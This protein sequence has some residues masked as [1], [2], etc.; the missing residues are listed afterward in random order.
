MTVQNQERTL[1]QLKEFEIFKKTSRRLFAQVPAIMFKPSGHIAQ[2][3]PAAEAALDMKA[4]LLIGKT[5]RQAGCQLLDDTGRRMPRSKQPWFT[6]ISQRSIMS[7][8]VTGM[9]LS[10][11]KIR[12]QQCTSMPLQKGRRKPYACIT[13]FTDITRL[14]ELQTQIVQ[15]QKM[16]AIAALASGLTHDFNNIL[17]SIRSAVQLV[18]VDSALPNPEHELLKDIEN[19][20]LRGAEL[21]KQILL[22]TKPVEQSSGHTYLKHQ[23]HMLRRLIKRT[24]PKNIHVHLDLCEQELRINMNPT[25]F[26]Q[27]L[28]NLIINARDAMRDGGDLNIKLSVV[29]RGSDELPPIP[30][31][32]VRTFAR[33]DVADTGRGIAP[34]NLSRIFEP[35]FTTRKDS[36][37]TGLGLPI[38]HNLVRQSGGQI[39]AE[40]TPG[41][42]SVFSI[43]LPARR[44]KPPEITPPL[45]NA[46]SAPITGYET[47]LVVDDEALITKSTAR[48][49]ERH[50]YHAIPAFEG[51]KALEIFEK[52]K[53]EV[54]LVLLDLEMPELSGRDCLARILAI[55]PGAKVV[56]I[57]GHILK[58]D[59]W[60]PIN[61]G[62]KAF[63]QKPFDSVALLHIVRNLLDA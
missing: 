8:I 7:N 1:R 40:S 13:I 41:K 57:T 42:G 36:G 48:F 62:A 33:V 49:L 51:K 43:L 14:K 18:L 38:V 24:I 39:T 32:R 12:W 31:T 63:V 10:D 52:Q 54:S 26:E 45:W 17:T 2:L 20:T 29:S 30:G 34:E 3:N 6:A 37:G 4:D 50:G 61:A 46:A 47:I 28:L 22:F 35:F 5:F 59:D 16:D 53:D 9:T 23:I 58:P 56:A 19:E 55:K 27:V 21:I 11:G 15:D 60:N 44:S 25:Y